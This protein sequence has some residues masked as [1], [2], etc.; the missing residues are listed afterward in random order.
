MAEV[1]SEGFLA[2]T[3]SEYFDEERQMYLSI[4]S[5]WNLDPSTPDGLKLASDS[6]IFSVLDEALQLA[7]NSKDPNKARDLELDIIGLLTGFKRSVGTPSTI[8]SVNLSGVSGTIIPEGSLVESDDGTQ[9]SVDSES[10]IGVS[11]SIEA[12]ITATQN[13]AIQADIG[14]V[15]NIVETISG[16]QSVS[17]TVV[18]IP[19]ENKQSNAETR[20]ERALTVG[21]PGNNQVE[22]TLGEL[23]AIQ[24][25]NK[26]KSYENDSGSVD[27][28][29]I[30][31]HSMLYVV[32]GGIDA[33]IA[34][35]IYLKKN[36]GVNLYGATNPV[37]VSVQSEKYN[38]TSV[39]IVFARP[40]YIDMT[41]VVDIVNDGT[42]P[43]NT[44]DLIKQAIT[45][46]T[47]GDLI[48]SSI[49]FNPFGFNIGEDVSPS[50]LYTPVNKVL[51]SYGSSYVTSLTV[52]G[53]TSLISIAFDALSVWSTANMTVNIT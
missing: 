53:G 25:V 8:P 10:V 38:L 23:G 14:S 9:W 47:Q 21:R 4:D 36:P 19:G 11:G 28:N 18:A 43:A 45:D 12:S 31:A 7:Y 39:D 2:K 49:G 26:Y 20:K 1:T 50:R 15:T 24:G 34:K 46:Y 33:D 22:S 5:D 51:G 35:A 52:N 37:T 40:S 30:P 16:W 32:D 44:D 13:G 48:E 6:E 41:I 29:S 27:A 17:N 3:Q 42:L